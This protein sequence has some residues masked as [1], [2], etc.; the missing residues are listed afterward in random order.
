MTEHHPPPRIRV[1]GRFI[2][3]RVVLLGSTLRD[4]AAANPDLGQSEPAVVAIGSLQ[5]S[6]R[7]VVALQFRGRVPPATFVKFRTVDALQF[8]VEAGLEQRDV[9][10]ETAGAG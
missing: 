7:P 1:V 9:A 3:V 5:T 2:E 8:E 6:R 4:V 10:R